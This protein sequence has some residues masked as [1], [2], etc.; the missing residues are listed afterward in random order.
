MIL[1]FQIQIP[2][3][4]H[5]SLWHYPCLSTPLRHIFHIISYKNLSLHDRAGSRNKREYFS[6]QLTGYSQSV[7]A[8]ILVI[9]QWLCFSLLFPRQNID[10][11]YF[12]FWALN[13]KT[14]IQFL[15]CLKFSFQNF[16]LVLTTE[17]Y[18]CHSL[19]TLV[20]PKTLEACLYARPSLFRLLQ[21]VSPRSSSNYPSGP[22]KYDLP[23]SKPPILLTSPTSYIHQTPYTSASFKAQC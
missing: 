19:Y 22:R 2:S 15:W 10:N 5:A 6:T 23:V 20:F 4:S 8:N 14:Y 12:F 13:P 18:F 16:S 3:P 17:F 21:I 11:T 7:I 1:E 9:T